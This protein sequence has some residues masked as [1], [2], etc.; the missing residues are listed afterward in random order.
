MKHKE[1]HGG[2]NHGERTMEET[3]STMRRSLSGINHGI[4]NGSV[5]EINTIE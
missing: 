2:R 4:I 1:I 5:Q 3:S